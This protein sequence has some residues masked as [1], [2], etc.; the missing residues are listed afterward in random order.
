MNDKIVGRVIHHLFYQFSGI[1]HGLLK[2]IELDGRSYMT[3]KHVMLVVAAIR[4]C[5]YADRSIDIDARLKR[6]L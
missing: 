2:V 6:F 3:C 4:H 5:L 1:L